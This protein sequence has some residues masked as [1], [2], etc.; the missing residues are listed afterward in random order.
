[1][2]VP[3]KVKKNKSFLLEECK[4]GHLPFKAV[5]AVYIGYKAQGDDFVSVYPCGC[6]KI[7]H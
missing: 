4:D 2:Q 1:M 3:G 5:L 7:R 6:K